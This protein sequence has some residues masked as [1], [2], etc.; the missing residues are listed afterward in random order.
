MDDLIYRGTAII[1]VKCG[2]L[3][4]RT[5][6]GRTDEGMAVLKETLTAIKE[7]PAVDAVEVVRC[8][9]CKHWDMVDLHF[10]KNICSKLM[11]PC[12]ES[13]FCS[14]AERREDG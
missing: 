6:Y 4:A 12:D 5:V 3:N 13:D 9:D 10:H 11:R 14:W 8:K 7:L 2:S 1:A